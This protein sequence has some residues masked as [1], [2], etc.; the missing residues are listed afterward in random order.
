M[1]YFSGQY[2]QT[3]SEKDL[4][5]IALGSLQE[6]QHFILLSYVIIEHQKKKKMAVHEAW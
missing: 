4:K 1:N 3:V 2:M 6:E 5:P